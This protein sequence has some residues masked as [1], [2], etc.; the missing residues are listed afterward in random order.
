MNQTFEVTDG[1]DRIDAYL[2]RVEPD[3]SRSFWQKL[4]EKGNVVVNDVAVK[5]SHKVQP[6]DM[7]TATIPQAPDFSDDKLPVIYQDADVI[8]MDKP[9]GMLTHA[10]GPVSEE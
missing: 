9:A 10:K 3:Y 2:A 7:I 6:G 5:P 8:V 1:G 4:V